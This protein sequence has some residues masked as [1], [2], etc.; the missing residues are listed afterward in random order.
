MK[1][2]F[3]LQLLFEKFL[4][5]RRTH[6]DIVIN[7]KTSSCE[8]PVILVGF[9]MKLE[10]CRQTFEKKKAQISNFIKIRSVGAELFHTNG[11]TSRNDEGNSCNS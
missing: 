8:V 6:R 5:L 3:S 1:L 11:Q 2:E 7:M 4:I 10:F 9:L